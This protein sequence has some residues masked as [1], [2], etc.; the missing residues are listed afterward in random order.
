MKSLLTALALAAT[1]P[2][3]AQEFTP[4]Q[5][6]ALQAWRD[7]RFGMFIHWGPV[8]L[9]GHEIGWSRGAQTP[10]E[11]YDNL[12]KRFNPEKF[13]ADE[14]VAVARAAGMKYMVLTTKHHDGFCLWDTKQT[15]YNIMN[16]PFGRDVVKEL[17]EAC[18]KGGI[19][20]GTY[21]STCDWH[22][23]DFPRT[24]PGG[25]TKRENPNLERYTEYL[26]A[27]STELVTKYGPLF[28]LW[29]D[30]PQEF[31]ARRGA[32][33]INLI[34]GLQPTIIVN[35]RTGARGDYDTPEQ[36][37]GGFQLDRPWE[38][39]MTISAH[40][41]WAWGGAKDGVKS[42]AACLDMLIRGAGGDGNVL[43]N[44]G[45]RPDG[46]IDPEQAGR[47]REVGDWLKVNGEAIYA[48][49]GGPYKPGLALAST[50]K[51]D[52]VY[53]HV[54]TWPDEP[55]TLP[56]LPAKVLSARLL[57]GGKAGVAVTDEGMTLT[58][59]P[60][61][62]DPL[63]TVIELT[64]DRPAMD[65]API[66]LGKKGLI[67]PEMKVE[68]SS[69]FGPGYEGGKATDGDPDTRWATPGGTREASLEVDFG[70]P[71]TFTGIEIEEATEGGMGE[72]VKSFEI[73]ARV[74]GQRKVLHTG[75]KLGKK[76][77]L[78][79]PA[80]V[81]AT[82]IRLQV[83]DASEGPTINEIRLIAPKKGK[84]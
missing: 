15:D 64:L 56:A 71:L 22:H 63:A 47:L 26:K 32:S 17:S 84:P 81:T 54:I 28:T 25:R 3:A 69:V 5:P 16:S 65:I 24:S 13:N 59:D 4:A 80:P 73:H 7:A 52:K 49:R 37:I 46:L 51:G 72:R 45:P 38:S 1:L 39:C 78:D 8:S 82:A 29:Y 20:F 34:R 67:T 2:A 61:D 60:A 23:P 57:K 40:N 48:T 83:L 55:L 50:R 62:R 31:D 41:A 79:L 21:Y 6:E 53:L 43:L 30:V 19:G 11:E 14:W 58:V 68:A 74:D 75:T 77:R 10:I 33:V 76:F 35:N 44:V 27:Q 18:K 12:Y 9:T 42:T 36:H 70:K 66:T